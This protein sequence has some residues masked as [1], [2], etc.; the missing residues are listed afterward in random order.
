M[1]NKY[2]LVLTVF[3]AVMVFIDKHDLMTQWQLSKS[4]DRLEKDK[5]YYNQKIQ[6]AKQDQL[7]IENNKEQFAREK[8]N[9]HKADEDV[10]IIEDKD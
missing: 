2:F 5:V 9:M 4:L 3:F 10:F 6:E 7:N 8:Y 1:R